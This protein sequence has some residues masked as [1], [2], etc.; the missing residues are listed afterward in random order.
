MKTLQS[1]TRS[2][3]LFAA[4]ALVLGATAS[5]AS[6]Q[7]APAQQTQS[8]APAAAD[9]SVYEGTYSMQAPNGNMI[10]LRTWV[11][12]NGKLNGELVGRG[13]QTVF[14]PSSEPHKFLHATIDDIWFLFTVVDGASIKA[15]M[16]QRG[17]EIS[18]PRTQ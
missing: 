4:L 8:S 2:T 17:R 9:L 11:D 1:G 15:T 7:D 16:H 10:D 5:P 3:L 12:E 14:R 13:Q 6:A 18:G